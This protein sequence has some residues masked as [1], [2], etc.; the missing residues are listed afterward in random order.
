[1]DN[2]LIEIKLNH[3]GDYFEID[4]GTIFVKSCDFTD[5]YS[6]SYLNKVMH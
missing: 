5:C 4:K 3:Y 6:T 2:F 1:M